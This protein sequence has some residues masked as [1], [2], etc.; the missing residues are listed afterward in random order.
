ML[1]MVANRFSFSDGSTAEHD[2]MEDRD[3]INH[4]WAIDVE[5]FEADENPMATTERE[6]IT[7]TLDKC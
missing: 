7:N 5:S 3:L 6:E 2:E 1:D 4:H